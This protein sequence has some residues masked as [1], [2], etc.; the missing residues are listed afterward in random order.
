MK[1]SCHVQ[2]SASHPCNL[3]ETTGKHQIPGNRIPLPR[4]SLS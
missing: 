2:R 1:K 4:D 3:L